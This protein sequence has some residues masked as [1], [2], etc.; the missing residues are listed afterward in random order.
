MKT[1]L[2]PELTENICKK[3]KTGI[4]AKVAAESEGI[5]EK[6]FYNWLER[7]ERAL[8]LAEK[9]I[10]YPESE[11]IFLQFLQSVRQ[12]TAEGEVVLVACKGER[13]PGIERNLCSVCSVGSGVTIKCRFLLVAKVISNKVER[14]AMSINKILR[15]MTI[16]GTGLAIRSGLKVVKK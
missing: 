6:T 14:L 9:D 5:T 3:L 16:Q 13:I 12:A 8:E 2:T 1:K 10:K 7:G 4:Y 11:E 15:K